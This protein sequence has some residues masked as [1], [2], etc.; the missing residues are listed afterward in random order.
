MIPDKVL[1]AA[2]VQPT[3]KW[4]RIKYKNKA[5]Y[6]VKCDKHLSVYQQYYKI[7]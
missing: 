5:G 6:E 2:D 4:S 3:N 7:W 1:T